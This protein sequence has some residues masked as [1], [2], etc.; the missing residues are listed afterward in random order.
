MARAVTAEISD[1]FQ[2]RHAGA[3]VR[4]HLGVHGD[5]HRGRR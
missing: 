4:I 3:G 2:K 5:Q 1:Y